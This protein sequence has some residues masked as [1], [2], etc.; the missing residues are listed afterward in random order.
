MALTHWLVSTVVLL[1]VTVCQLPSHAQDG[2]GSGAP[3]RSG[4]PGE[5]LGG[6][7]YGEGNDFADGIT[8]A[9]LFSDDH[10]DCLRTYGS[11]SSDM[12][13]ILNLCNRQM[14][15]QWVEFATAA[16]GGGAMDMSLEGKELE[17]IRE[18]CRQNPP[19][20]VTFNQCVT[21]QCRLLA[22]LGSFNAS[23]CPQDL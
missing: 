7:W 15:E 10:Q 6:I 22:S 3:G 20:N 17:F 18:Q 16:S 19:E 21:Q 1:F 12:N 11:V 2:G 23:D 8:N 13:A 9:M 5:S 14:T 4:G